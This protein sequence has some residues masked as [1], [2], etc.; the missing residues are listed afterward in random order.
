MR[1]LRIQQVLLDGGPE[2]HVRNE[3]VVVGV[4]PCLVAADKLA[5]VGFD[6]TVLGRYLG[7]SR[8][9]R[10]ATLGKTCNASSCSSADTF[11]VTMVPSAAG[12]PAFSAS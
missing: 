2:G 9:P 1:G 4:P 7:E 5:G 6:V 11:A 8:A 3:A 12:T 10:P